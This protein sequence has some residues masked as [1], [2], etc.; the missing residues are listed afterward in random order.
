MGRYVLAV[1]IGTSSARA[2]VF[3]ADGAVESLHQE[4]YT[5]DMPQPGWQEQDPDLIAGRV[6]AAIR[7]CLAKTG[8]RTGIAGLGLSSQMYSIFPVD[9]EGRPL[10]KSIIWADSRSEGQT[11]ELRA[12]YGPKHFYKHTGCPLDSIYPL[13]KILWIKQARPEVFAKAAKFVS[14][15]EYIV[16]KL[17]GEFLADYS[18]G[19]A[20]GLLNVRE[21][22]WEKRALEAAG[23]SEDRLSRPL[24]VVSV[25]GLGRQGAELTGLPEGFPVVLGAGDGPL[26]NLGSGA[27]RPG[28]VNIDLGTSGAART[29]VTQP[30]LDADNRLWCYCLTANTWALGGILN[31]VGNLYKWFA[32]NIVFYGRAPVEDGMALLNGYAEKSPAGAKGL[33]FL[34]FLLKARS[35]YWDGKLKGG[36]YGLNPGHDLG[37]VARALVES[38]TFNMLSI[39][40]ALRDDTPQLNRILFTGGLSQAKVWGQTLADVLGERLVLPVTKEG[41]AGGAAILAMYALG[42]KAGLE[43]LGEN[44]T[45]GEYRPDADRHRRYRA[46]FG[47]YRRLCEAVRQIP[48]LM[49]ATE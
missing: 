20:S 41:S 19:S 40:E 4:Y 31:N 29:I 16:E 1:D 2:I 14:I 46:I 12:T 37:D 15:K 24:D 43:P 21:H 27:M 25:H 5:V 48:A 9:G 49:E 26:A 44:R 22:R 47:N 7:A 36:L 45:V 18:S 34:P 39:V 13:S 23:I 6:F 38:V 3:A 11:E 30:T 10:L 17:V 8:V 42:L 33:Y 32:D 35:P 28:D